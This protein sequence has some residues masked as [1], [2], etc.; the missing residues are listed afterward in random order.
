[1]D[2]LNN[3][4]E[5]QVTG[6]YQHIIHNNVELQVTRPYQHTIHSNVEH[7]D[8]GQCQPCNIIHSSVALRDMPPLDS[9]PCIMDIIN[10][11]NDV[12]QVMEDSIHSNIHNIIIH[13]NVEHPDMEA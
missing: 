8:M 3:N 10:H 4:A 7:R 6:P 5:L 9:R 12:R 1:M 2:C 13:N 11:N